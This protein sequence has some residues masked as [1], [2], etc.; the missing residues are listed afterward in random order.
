[1]K[2][3]YFYK[4]PLSNIYKKPNAFSE[5]TSQILYGEKFKIIS[6]N[7][8]WIKIK[9]S[10][11]NY[12]GYIKNKYYTK[13]HQP[14]HKIFTL[15]ANIYNKQKNKTKNFLPFASRISMINENK[16]FVEFEK[17][18]WIKKK[19][20]KKINHIEKDYLKVLK[21]FLKIKYLWGGKTYRGI[22]C[23]AI[24]QLFFYYNNKFYP[25]DT[26]D[27]IKY[28]AKKNK[29]KVFKKG[30]II[31]WKG[32]VAV[33]INAQKLIHAYGPEKKV[34]IMNIKETIN[35]IERTAKLTV[36][37]ISPIKY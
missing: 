35:R 2:D 24:L 20:I 25:R 19:D 7:K 22:D 23:S 37:K 29:S 11:D 13:D 15:K 32:H 28:S 21:M 5:V 3:N 6:K 14:T 1:M 18:K 26:K 4:K 9:V 34:L 36:K 8:N 30:D 27:Q 33:C 17:D 31:F 16:K 12:T 10:F